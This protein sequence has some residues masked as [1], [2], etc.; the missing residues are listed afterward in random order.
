MV[1]VSAGWG[2]EATR[3]QA[4]V[5]SVSVVREWPGHT[6]YTLKYFISLCVSNLFL[7]SENGRV[8]L[9]TP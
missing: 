7:L 3:L 6:L 2:D 1:S 4:A 5:S 9:C 8:I